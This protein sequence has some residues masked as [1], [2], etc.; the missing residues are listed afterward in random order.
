MKGLIDV[1]ARELIRD[2]LELDVKSRP[3]IDNILSRQ[4]LLNHVVAVLEE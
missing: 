2:I 3:S 1:D 4:F